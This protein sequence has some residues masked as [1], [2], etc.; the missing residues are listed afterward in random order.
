MIT[1]KIHIASDHA[2]FQLKEKIKTYFSNDSLLIDLGTSDNNSV[3]YPDFAHK[4]CK[5]IVDKIPS[6]GILICGSGIG[7]SMVANRYSDIRAALCLDSNMAKLARE[8]NNA[9]ILVLGSRLI[10]WQ[11][12]IKCVNIF[13]S[14][15]FDGGR[16]QTRL[17]KLNEFKL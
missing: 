15:Q 11:E 3:D 2:G 1:T 12:A 5:K 7:M 8:H 14:T 13:F 4:M 9:N 17:E 6:Y 10:S 16:H